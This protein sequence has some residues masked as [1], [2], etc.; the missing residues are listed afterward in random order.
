MQ[1]VG[2]DDKR[3]QAPR[4][5]Y[6]FFPGCSTAGAN[7]GGSVENVDRFTN[8]NAPHQLPGF[9]PAVL[10]PGEKI[11]RSLGANIFVLLPTHSLRLWRYT[12]GYK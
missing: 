5:R 2:N 3:R 1:T 6:N 7:P 8:N 10:H 4:G 9:A 11:Y 12:V